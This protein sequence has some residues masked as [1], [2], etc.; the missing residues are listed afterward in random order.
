MSEETEFVNHE[1]LR[2]SAMAAARRMIVA[3]VPFPQQM[4]KHELAVVTSALSVIKGIFIATHPEA[5]GTEYFDAMSILDK[6]E[7]NIKSYFDGTEN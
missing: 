3:A 7:Q 2:D 6:F 5:N 1:N 4:T